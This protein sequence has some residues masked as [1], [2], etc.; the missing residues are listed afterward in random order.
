M[1]GAY[2]AMKNQWPSIDVRLGVPGSER[3]IATRGQLVNAV[4]DTGS[5][6]TC[7]KEALAR[8]IYSS[9]GSAYTP[10]WNVPIAVPGGSLETH[11]VPLLIALD[12]EDGEAVHSLI[13]CVIMEGSFSQLLIGNDILSNLALDLK[14][15][16]K[17]RTLSLK[18]YTWDRFEDDV[19]SAYRAL[20]ATVS[21]NLNLAGFQIDLLA[22]EETQS[23]QK[24]RLAVECKYYKDPIGNRI[25]NDFARVV[26]TLKQANLA[27]RGVII[28]HA[29]FTQ[30]ATLV[31]TASGVDLLT[32]DDLR[33]QSAGSSK[34]NPPQSLP[35][36]A[37]TLTTPKAKEAYQCFVLLPFEP[38]L[39]DVYHLGI[40]EAV[41]SLGGVCQRA[42]EIQYLGG[43]IEKIYDA[44]RSADVIVAEVTRPNPNVFYEVGFAHALSKPVVLITRDIQTSPFDLRGHNHII[45]KSIVDLRGQLGAMLTQLF[46]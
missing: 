10:I 24:L 4:L 3:E 36:P 1:H 38:E 33:Q 40:R 35:E 20:G 37:T 7:I 16:Y 32:L 30:D 17:N 26:A 11:A 18:R 21:R 12:L 31:A 9:S 14:I 19:A 45:Y 39:D 29:G 25:V 23:K 42:D 22:Q 5:S 2:A 41:N 28:S 44:I 34:Q 43:I 27:D 8:Q 46:R 15:D 13:N 6:M